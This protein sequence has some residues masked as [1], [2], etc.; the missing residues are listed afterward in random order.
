MDRDRSE[1]V[2]AALEEALRKD[3]EILSLHGQGGMGMVFCARERALERLVAI[4]A[5]APGGALTPA[6]RD[7]F[8]R[9][10]RLAA[11]LSH[12]SIVPIFNFGETPTSPSIPFIVMSFVRG[13]SL[14]RQLRHEGRLSPDATRH[15]LLDLSD[16]L[17][18]AHTRGI[19]HRDIKPE[20]VL[21]AAESRRAML[22]DFGIAKALSD[23][24]HL[25]QSGVAIGT[26]EYMS[27]EQA[28]GGRDIDHR[29]DLYSLGALGYTMLAGRPPH[30]GDGVASVMAKHLLEDPVP[31]R[32]LA[33][34]APQDLVAAIS[35]CLEKNPERRW[36][37]AHALH[38]ALAREAS[39]DEPVAEELRAITGFGAFMV[40]V[41]LFAVVLA[42]DGWVSN[43][44][45]LMVIAPLAGL[46]IAVGFVNHARGIAANG[47]TLRDVL[48][49]SMW[50]PKWW[51][52]WWP[53]S[54]RRPGDVW[55]CLPTSARLTRALSTLI[56]A[57]ILVWL[58]VRSWLPSPTR[59]GVDSGMRWLPGLGLFVV[60]TGLLRWTRIGF[61]F[62]DAWR[63]LFGPTVGA[64]FWNQ[65]HVSGVLVTRPDAAPACATPPPDTARA[66]LHA[67]E[68]AAGRLGGRARAAGGAATDAAHLLV[69]DIERL[70]AEIEGL[71][72]DA[73]P[74]ELARVERRLSELRETQ[75]EARQHLEEYAKLMRAQADL[76]EVKRLDREDANGTLGAIWTVME[77]L[78]GLSGGGTPLET[79]LLERLRA[80]V[81]AARA[82]PRP[83]F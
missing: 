12:P 48:S 81:A 70:D 18:H 32:E 6:A 36:P 58:V 5:L 20:N 29:S 19:I 49:V 64:T 55:E 11:A 24:S 52:L 26:P 68:D 77:R 53:R 65:P 71:S 78:R 27:P 66:V 17:D 57:T 37:D 23:G 46:L 8:H 28:A 82:R 50:P 33:P 31:L 41:L 54:L 1:W 59:V 67:I 4:K 80:L 56:F 45:L 61:A 42:V 34:T 72:G 40:I 38:R 30:Q 2:R 62:K 73:S 16:A 13:E 39:E 79:E 69:N 83:G 15:I 74:E 21:I 3:Y 10:A 25:T 51:G 60:A 76:L 14:G 7:R 75:R 35:R 63:L 43:D 22:A 44:G 47:Y 9:E